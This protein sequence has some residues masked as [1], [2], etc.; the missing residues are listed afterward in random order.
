MPVRKW[1]VRIN[2]GPSYMVD[3]LYPAEASSEAV[4]LYRKDETVAEEDRTGLI[5]YIETRCLNRPRG[6]VAV[7]GMRATPLDH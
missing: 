1:K 7:P 2:D 4:L 6:R 5:W 3:A